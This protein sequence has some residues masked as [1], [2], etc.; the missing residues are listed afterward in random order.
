[1]S[2]CS[3]V[4]SSDRPWR[5]IAIPR[6]RFTGS[7]GKSRRSQNVSRCFRPPRGGRSADQARA[8]FIM[9][10]RRAKPTRLSA[11]A[12]TRCERVRSAVS[13]LHAAMSG[14]APWLQERCTQPGLN[15]WFV[16]SDELV[17]G[18][19]SRS[20]PL[21]GAAPGSRIP[22]RVRSARSRN[23]IPQSGRLPESAPSD[24]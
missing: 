22:H 11:R 20:V 7:G 16:L 19:C 23:P 9:E 13:A 24:E 12:R 17:P 1:M 10:M 18:R 2:F 8:R 3:G 21:G 4:H 5:I 6:Q 14:K 15:R